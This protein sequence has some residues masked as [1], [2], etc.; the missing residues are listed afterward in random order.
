MNTRKERS[1]IEQTVYWYKY[2]FNNYGSAR[3]IDMQIENCYPI[4]TPG[5]LPTR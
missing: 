2:S 5:L 4:L 3:G 1:E